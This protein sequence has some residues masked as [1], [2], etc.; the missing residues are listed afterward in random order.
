MVLRYDEV[1]DLIKIIDASACDELVLETGDLKLVVRRRN[2]STE[3]RPAGRSADVAAAPQTA[4]AQPSAAPTAMAAPR[5]A[6]SGQGQIEIRAPM[7]G[8]FY[9]SPSPNAPPFVEVGARVE[10]GEPVGLIEVMK[11]F[12]TLYA[13]QAGRVAHVSAENDALVEYGQV[14]FVLDPS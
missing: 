2:A 1:A 6:A 5:P 10:V 4:Q 3:A 11:L 14:L 9:R 7:V 13:E 8:T 12:T